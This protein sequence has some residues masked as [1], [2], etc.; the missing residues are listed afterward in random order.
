MGAAVLAAPAGGLTPVGG[1]QEI[2]I[3]ST[4]PAL[5]DALNVDPPGVAW[6]PRAKRFLVTWNH[7]GHPEG[8]LFTTGRFVD[9]DGVPVGPAFRV[10]DGA[11]ADLV[12]NDA[13]GEFALIAGGDLVR[14]DGSGRV[15]GRDRFSG[16]RN[17]ELGLGPPSVV[18]DGRTGAY[19]VVWLERST[20]LAPLRLFARAV[21]PG[22]GA[23]E[24]TFPVAPVPATP[25]LEGLWTPDLA[26]N[27][28]DGEFVVVWT[29]ATGVV[30]R[31]LRADGDPVGDVITVSVQ[32][33]R[34]DAAIVPLP[35]SPGFLAAWSAASAEPEGQV[36]VFARRI[37][38]EG[39][40]I[41]GDDHRITHVLSPNGVGAVTGSVSAAAA[42]RAGEVLVVADVDRIHGIPSSVEEA[43]AQ[44]VAADGSETGPDDLQLSGDASAGDVGDKHSAVAYAPAANRYLVAWEAVVH[45]MEPL[46]FQVRVRVLA[47]GV[48]AVAATAPICAAARP[49]VPS[50]VGVGRVALTVAQARI[51]MR[52]ARAA[53]R[54]AEAAARWL[55]AGVEARDLCQGGIAAGTF[56][57]G[58][59]PSIGDPVARA[60]PVPR[61]VTI[62]AAAPEPRRLRLDAARLA[63][64]QATAREAIALVAAL[65]RRLDAGLTGGDIADGAVGVA[66]LVPGY[67]PWSVPGGPTDPPTVV[68]RAV[69]SRTAGRITI[70][71]TQMR[72]NRRIA[73][74]ALL[75]ADALIDRL[76]DGIGPGEIRDG[77]LTAADLGPEVALST[78]P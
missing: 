28:L 44:V 61:P 46:D 76:E 32:E 56:R 3:E 16:V 21:R 22:S 70:S 18:V 60:A 53:L 24:T 64:D 5:E 55:D 77:T 13:T 36:D 15:L 62:A 52:I 20:P 69:A 78:A 63:L 68:P 34:H 51:T 75:R 49:V 26:W 14:L 57:A 12:H 66:H 19:L 30:A 71:A 10:A 37:L 48:P 4:I 27:A 74:A 41:P 59:V 58:T 6:D 54:R 9:V 8:E 73:R 7:R 42:E 38:P 33:R 67:R 17:P 72:I 43:F 65:E 31:R 23:G 11:G 50:Q 47:A 29:S 35:G 1:I 45:R 39:R 2:G 25:E 40:V